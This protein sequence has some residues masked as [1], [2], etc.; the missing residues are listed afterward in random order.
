M[1]NTLY[2]VHDPMC[3]WCWAYQP[4]W[5]AVCER[6]A[7]SVDVVY[8]L[9]G[10]AADSDQVMSLQMQQS[11]QAIWRRIE[12]QLGTHFNHDFWRDCQPRRSTYPACRAVIAAQRQG[13]AHEMIRAI[14]SAYYLEA[15]NPSD[16][17]LLIVLARQLG[18]DV[19]RFC[20]DLIADGTQSELDRQCRFA[21]QL[22]IQG[23]PSLVLAT[24]SGQYHAVKLD[25]SNPQVTLVDIDRLMDES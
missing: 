23:F 17:E 15:K 16:N 24:A 6:L 4:A 8:L 9:G 14:Q 22:P 5:S 18:L 13:R 19:E 10:L 11:I 7:D 25:Y 2:Y 3:S 1:T 21:R 20:V 12:C